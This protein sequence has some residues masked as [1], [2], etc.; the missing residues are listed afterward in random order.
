MSSLSQRG[1]AWWVLTSRRT[2][3]M[4]CYLDALFEHKHDRVPFNH[5]V[6]ARVDIPAQA[7]QELHEWIRRAMMDQLFDGHTSLLNTP[8]CAAAA[9]Q[10]PVD[11]PAAHQTPEHR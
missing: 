9:G 7:R 3:L 8:E 10:C 11:R 1:P 4:L 5:A 6:Q 2:P